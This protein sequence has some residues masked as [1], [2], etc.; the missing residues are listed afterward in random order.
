M[1]VDRQAIAWVNFNDGKIFK[2]DTTQTDPPLYGHGVRSRPGGFTPQLGM[3]FVTVSA[4]NH[5]E[6]LYVISG[7]TGPGA[8]CP[9]MAT[10]PGARCWGWAWA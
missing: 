7:N 10:T 3:G 2:V 4:A 8:L 6:S 1:A 9:S 5:A